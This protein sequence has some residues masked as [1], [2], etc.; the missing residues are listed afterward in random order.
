M[1]ERITF[2]K[3]LM[4][5][6]I[7][8][9][10]IAFSHA[11]F[12][13]DRFLDY[14]FLLYCAVYVFAPFLI[15]K[16]IQSF[17]PHIICHLL[18]IAMSLG[19]FAI[20]KTDGVLMTA[21]SLFSVILS[22]KKSLGKKNNMQPAED[23]LHLATL[24]LF[25]F[26]AVL[27]RHYSYTA[28]SRL[29]L[30]EAIIYTVLFVN[31]TINSNEE[32]YIR[33]HTATVNIPVSRIR[34][35]NRH[36]KLIF[37]CI[38]IMVMLVVSV[39][40]IALPRLNLTHENQT[41]ADTTNSITRDPYDFDFSKVDTKEPS[42]LA[43]MLGYIIVFVTGILIIITIFAIIIICIKELYGN[44]GGPA[45]NKEEY[46]PE[47]EITVEALNP[48]AQKVHKPRLPKDNAFK[49]RRLYHDYI[50]N[51]LSKSDRPKAGIILSSKTPKEISSV[52]RMHGKSHDTPAADIAFDAD[53]QM[54]YEKVRY[55]DNYMPADTEVARMKDLT[56]GKTS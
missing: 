22:F 25:P 41:H 37:T 49:I 5:A 47:E 9:T 10:T 17:I 56:S 8:H 33:D 45:I 35:L 34:K 36:I 42:A 16:H 23:A 48:F 30:I 19:F 7:M 50:L 1:H 38:T 43:T 12:E 13:N 26:F 44:L 3:L 40:D 54:L 15:R 14:I 52:I 53:I 11:S 6:L 31:Y 39:L 55:A 28:F 27:G 21:A 29:V 2:Q 18:L 20:S 32:M 24:L 46:I 51:K 4:T